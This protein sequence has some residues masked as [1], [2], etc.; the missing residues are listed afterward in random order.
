MLKCSAACSVACLRVCCASVAK[1]L[2]KTRAQKCSRFLI[3]PWKKFQ[4]DQTVFLLN[5]GIKKFSQ[6]AVAV[7]TRKKEL[8]K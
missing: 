6:W 1:L 3:W 8:M 4:V 7:Q 5:S 2:S